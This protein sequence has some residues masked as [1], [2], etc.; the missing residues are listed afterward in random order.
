MMS[1]DKQ[2]KS[3]TTSS[4]LLCFQIR[5]PDIL[6]GPSHVLLHVVLVVMFMLLI[7]HA[8]ANEID[9]VK[10]G[11]FNAGCLPFSVGGSVGI[12]RPWVCIEIAALRCLSII[13]AK[14]S[15]Q[16]CI[17]LH[18]QRCDGRGHCMCELRYL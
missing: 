7:V 15:S 17:V 6:L 1:S 10:A 16:F 13:E 9:V 18:R 11:A 12:T 2:T 4:A 14:F 5:L 3:S 8:M